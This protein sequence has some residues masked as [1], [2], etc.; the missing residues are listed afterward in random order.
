VHIKCKSIPELSPVIFAHFTTHHPHLNSTR[1]TNILHNF[2]VWCVLSS[3][4]CLCAWYLFDCYILTINL[5]VVCVCYG[6]LTTH[7]KFCSSVFNVMWIV[8]LIHILHSPQTAN[9]KEQTS[10]ALGVFMLTGGEWLWLCFDNLCDL[11]TNY[12]MLLCFFVLYFK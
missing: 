12:Y 2:L 11:C 5:E 10:S 9:N 8:V 3:V 1:C 7:H 6:I 4:Y